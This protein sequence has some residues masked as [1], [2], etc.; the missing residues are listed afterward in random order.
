MTKKQWF[1]IVLFYMGGI[2]ANLIYHL[3]PSL[4][5]TAFGDLA[6][7]WAIIMILMP[8]GHLYGTIEHLF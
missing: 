6:A 5:V 8:I 4:I 2:I 7:L 1:N 3:F